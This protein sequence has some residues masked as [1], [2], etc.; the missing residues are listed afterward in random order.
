MTFFNPNFCSLQDFSV[1]PSPL[2]TRGFGPEDKGKGR[3]KTDRWLMVMAADNN[4]LMSQAGR[5][6]QC[7]CRLGGRGEYNS[8]EF[9]QTI[10]K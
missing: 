2:W 10:E 5:H 1:S 9:V 6:M 3:T 4:A 7:R 8:N